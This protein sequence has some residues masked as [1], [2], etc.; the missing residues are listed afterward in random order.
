MEGILVSG[1]TVHKELAQIG[2]IGVDNTPGNAARIFSHLANAKVIV[3]DIIQTER[4]SEKAN[5]TFTVNK[6]D[7]ADA[8]KV[9]KQIKDSLNCED[10]FVRED[11]AAVSAIGVGMKTHYGVADKMFQALADAKVN[12]DSI[13]TSEIRI[14]CII[15]IDQANE[16][17]TA[18]CDAFELDKPAE[19]RS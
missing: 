11:I 17:L 16:A 18:I 12:I 2:L 10:V 7:L 15:D 4:S 3:N 13:T 9:I 19:Q 5:V 8:Q 14:T 1:A 6:T